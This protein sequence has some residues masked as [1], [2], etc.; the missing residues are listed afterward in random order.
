MMN[1]QGK[2]N[3]KADHTRR[4]FTTNCMVLAE[5]TEVTEMIK[6]CQQMQCITH[7]ITEEAVS[8]QAAVSAS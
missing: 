4:K 7:W 5:I 3:L 6:Y 8:A 1:S 2:V